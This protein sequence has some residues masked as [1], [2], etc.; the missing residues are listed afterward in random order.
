MSKGNKILV[1]LIVIVIFFGIA[2]YFSNFFINLTATKTA[3]AT[4]NGHSITLLIARTEK[5]KEI[6]L[7]SR[8]NLPKDEGMIFPFATPGNYPFWMKDMK[9][10]IDIIYLRDQKIVTIL[11]NVKPPSSL[12]GNPPIY[13]PSAPSDTVIEINAGLSDTY[14]LK[15]GEKIN[16]ENF[17]N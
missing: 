5:E 8:K 7:S 15:T 17:G 9:F 14:K 2:Y 12:I 3:R 10:S 13:T 4:I 1:I 16:Y 11:K 6:G